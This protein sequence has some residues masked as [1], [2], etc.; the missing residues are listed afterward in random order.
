MCCIM[1]LVV[2]ISMFSVSVS[3]EDH[4][5]R[6][7]ELSEAECITFIKAQGVSIPSDY[8]DELMWGAFVKEIIT[9]VEQNPGTSLYFNYSVVHSFANDIKCAVNEYYGVTES[10]Q[11]LPN[12]RKVNTLLHSEVYGEWTDSFEDYNCYSYALGITNDW[13]DPGNISGLLYTVT[14]SV[15]TVAGYVKSDLEELGYVDV[16]IT[17]NRPESSD[18]NIHQKAICVRIKGGIDY[19]F[20]KLENDSWYHKPSYTNT[21]RY[22]HMPSTDMIWTNEGFYK[23][24]II[25]PTIEYTSAIQ[26]IIYSE[27]HTYEYVSNNSG[28]HISLCT[29]CGET[30]STSEACTYVYKTHGDNTH[31]YVCS[32]CG[33]V[34]IDHA[35]CLFNANNICRVCGAPKNGAV[36]NQLEEVTPG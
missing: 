2:C 3:A 35:A 29:D 22:K 26:Y 9:L 12:T 33:Y 11:T 4:K 20:M 24:S 17:P 31:S 28:Y 18:L 16:I 1:V 25:L 10:L 27:P 14:L 6:L 8:E 23:G 34:K 7:S 15:Y 5:I 13:L 36:I 32:L 19:H 21:L 30:G